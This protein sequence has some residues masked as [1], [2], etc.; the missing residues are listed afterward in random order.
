M[1]D[2]L[3]Q[4]AAYLAA[5]DR[6]IE[7]AGA[8]VTEGGD[9][10]T[11]RR[12]EPYTDDLLLSHAA[13]LDEDP[14]VYVVGTVDVEEAAKRLMEAGCPRATIAQLEGRRSILVRHA[15]ALCRECPEARQHYECEA[16]RDHPG[17]PSD[18]G[19]CPDYR[20]AAAGL[21]EDPDA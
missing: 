8:A 19:D 16:C 15:P 14:P 3:A 4:H 12:V 18:W 20:D 13:D 9:R 5:L 11:I 10:W 7:N 1:P 2:P 21:P 17:R 6:Q